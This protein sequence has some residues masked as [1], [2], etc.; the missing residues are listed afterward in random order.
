[1]FDKILIA[2]RGEIACRIARTAERMGIATVA[3]YSEADRDALHV[4]RC[5]E[6]FLIGAAA[7]A[8]SYLR[9]PR[10]I[11]V[12]RQAGAQAIH[13][14]YGFLSENADFADACARAN[15]AFIG[16]PPD[17]IRAMGDKRAA[18]NLMA[19]AGVPVLEGY[20]EDQRAETLKAAADRIGYPIL[21]KAVYGG[22]GK[23]MRMVERAD[24]FDAAL[25]AVKRE[26]SASF[27]DQR[28]LLE[29]YL[30]RARHIEVQVFVDENGNAV[31]LFDRDCSVQRR[32]QKVIEEAP[33]PGLDEPLREAMRATAVRAARSIGYVGAGTVEFLLDADDAGGGFYFMEMNTRLQVEHPVTEMIVAQDLV[34]WQLRVAAGMP[35]PCRQADLRADGH[36]MEARIYAENPAND[37]L[38]ATGAL[39]VYRPPPECDWLRVDSGVE[40]GAQITPHYDPMIAK[41]IVRGR[42]REAARKRLRDA[43]AGFDIAGVTT[44][45]EFLHAVTGLDDFIAP[46]PDTALIERNRATL[47]ADQ[48]GRPEIYLAIATLFENAPAATGGPSGIAGDPFSPWSPTMP[49]QLNLPVDATCVWVDAGE[50][51][52]TVRFEQEQAFARIDGERLPVALTPL[53]GGKFQFRHGAR[54]QV[55]SV[56]KVAD[57]IHI[58]IGGQRRALTVADKSGGNVNHAA[59]EA[60]LSAPMPGTVVA[61]V[62][63]ENQRVKRG[64]LLLT[65][66]AMKMEHTI[67]APHDGLVTKLFFRQGEQVREGDQLLTLEV[68][69]D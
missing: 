1:M 22:G 58:N 69:D 40:Q 44:N 2:N 24:D 38:P 42:D 37:F 36:A 15:L 28:V 68:R 17:A 64:A 19:E 63:G 31:H 55:V 45:L 20:C 16:P 25:A 43:L 26:S 4:K 65:L 39:A 59:G 46:V 23:G 6:A 11:E 34:E 27:A 35:L 13:P 47:F 30:W 52:Y 67:S 60:G 56:D 3:V 33:A 10:I 50:R 32:R 21:L 7:A 62:V 41:L 14:G 12:A 18:K 8:D 51:E 61:V 29:K 49:W 66:E 5:G 57:T 54:T 9:A 48:G 53:A